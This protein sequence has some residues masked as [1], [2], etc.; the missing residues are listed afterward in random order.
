MVHR[1]ARGSA[2]GLDAPPGSMPSV[3]AKPNAAAAHKAVS[4]LTTG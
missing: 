3:A 1:F 2:P 4:N